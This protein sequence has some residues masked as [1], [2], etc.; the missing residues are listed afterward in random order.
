MRIQKDPET[1][2]KNAEPTTVDV[3]IVGAGLAGT[4]LATL[5]GR[6]GRKVALIDPH[7]THPDEF[8]AEKLGT[9]QGRLFEKL[10]LDSI[11]LPLMTPMD[12][13]HVFRL[14]QLFARDRRVEYGFS[15]GALINGLRAALPPQVP[16]T[17][18]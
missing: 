10:G 3:A 2:A 15:Y 18:A 1:P 6:D 5:L 17:V 11:V 8:R 7:Q 12:D 13:I 16:V 9:G 14:G 4:T